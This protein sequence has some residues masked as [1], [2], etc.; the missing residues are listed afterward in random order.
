MLAVSLANARPTT[1]VELRERCRAAGLWLPKRSTAHDLASTLR[2]I[3]EWLEVVDAPDEQARVARLNGMLAAHTSH[4]RM[5]NHAGDGW[6]IHFREDDQP[7][8]QVLASITSI[9]TALHLTQRGMS[10]LGRCHAPGCDLVYADCSPRG[11]QRYCSVRCANRA[12]VSRHR[13]RK[14]GVPL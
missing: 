9:G 3:D 2:L 12:A 7:L 14:R 5:T 1:T 10:R 6:H 11:T 8:G 4:P 13:A